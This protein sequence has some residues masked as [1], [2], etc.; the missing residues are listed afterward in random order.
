L[1]ARYYDPA[2]GRFNRLDPF[3]G[4]L[5]DPQSLHKYLY[6]CDDPINGIDP[7]G[8]MSIGVAMASAFNIGM[9]VVGVVSAAQTAYKV[10]TQ[11]IDALTFWDIISLIPFGY[12]GA[13]KAYASGMQGLKNLA[14]TFP[15]FTKVLKRY[16][17]DL[18]QVTVRYRGAVSA[19]FGTGLHQFFKHSAIGK[20]LGKLDDLTVGSNWVRVTL[21]KP[22]ARSGKG[23][24][25]DITIQFPN[26][27]FA[28]VLDIKSV[29]QEIFENGWLPSV[30]YLY[31]SKSVAIKKQREGTLNIFDGKGYLTLY[32]YLPYPSLYQ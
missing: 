18:A 25:P 11:G 5:D 17:D 27:K 22:I 23:S 31:E 7:S 15:A 9:Q 6:T 1:R 2:T 8:E 16:G 12:A 4:N 28:I 19:N 26:F 30:I 13:G 3:F 24:R 20:F 32:L 10:I 14:H 21:D 29:P